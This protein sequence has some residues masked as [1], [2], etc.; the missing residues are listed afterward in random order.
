MKFNIGDK[1]VYF[2]K[3]GHN[4]GDYINGKISDVKIIIDQKLIAKLENALAA[5]KLGEARYTVKF[6]HP[7]ND[8][9]GNPDEFGC[10]TNEFTLK[11]GANK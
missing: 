6:D 5:A 2:N 8:H 3:I 1:V 4:D 10:T 11:P 7:Y 9:T